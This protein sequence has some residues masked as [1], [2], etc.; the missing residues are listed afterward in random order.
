MK[1]C[2]NDINSIKL[3]DIVSFVLDKADS[4]IESCSLNFVK[5]SEQL[6]MSKIQEYSQ[7][8]KKTD[9]SDMDGQQVKDAIENVSASLFDEII[10]INT[11]YLKHGMK[12]GARFLAELV[13]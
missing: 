5:D 7:E 1:N 10:K 12:I 2:K 9:F 3:D 8:I 13:F 4:Q 11:I 6:L